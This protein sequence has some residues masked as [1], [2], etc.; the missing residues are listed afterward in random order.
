MEW[1]IQARQEQHLSIKLENIMYLL[2]P[3]ISH[4]DYK[5]LRD[6]FVIP[7]RD[8]ETELLKYE[9]F[10]PQ[11]SAIWPKAKGKNLE[12]FYLS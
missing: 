5:Y 8:E 1:T 10:N 2:L 7:Q 3:L 11:Y 12:K 9:I 6:K 4:S